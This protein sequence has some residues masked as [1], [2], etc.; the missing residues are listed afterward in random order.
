MSIINKPNDFSPNTT[1]SSSEVNANFDTIYNDYN[2]GITAANL[3]TDSVTTAKI[4][5]SNITTAKIADANVTSAKLAEAFFRGRLQTDNSNSIASSAP[6]GLTVQHG[7]VQIL[8]DGS[9]SISQT[10][11]FPV[12]FTQV[13]TVIATFNGATATDSTP[14]T[15]LR[16]FE[17]DSG[18]VWARATGIS[19]TTA[20]VGVGSSAT[21][22]NTRY[23]SI[24]WMAIGTV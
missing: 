3:A 6:T 9:S 8:G 16:D 14:G 1:I 23:Y 12:A 21:F 22:A 11:T 4:A 10:V 17:V 2:G 15:T 7:F 24:S 19:T 5:D 20:I 18:T 13:Y